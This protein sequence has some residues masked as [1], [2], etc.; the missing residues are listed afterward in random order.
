MGEKKLTVV[1][2]LPA[3]QSGGVERGTL[4]VAGALVHAGHRS[5]V[6]SAGGSLLRELVASG[7][8]HICL[9]VGRKSLLT[10]LQVRRLRKILEQEHVDIL[11]ARSRLP[12]WIAWLAWRGMPHDRRP[13]FVTTVHGLYS[14]NAYSRI[15]TRGERVI[16]VSDTARQYILDNYSEVNPGSVV[17]I[18]RGVSPDDFPFGYRPDPDWLRNWYE[19]YPALKGSRVLTLPGR[20][21][22]LK[23]HE[24]FIRLIGELADKGIQVYG[25]IVG[26]LDPER[27]QY[28][29]ELRQM[30]ADRKLESRIIFTGQRSDI[31]E[32]YA[33]S[34][35]VL[36][37]SDKPESFGRTI[38]EAL[39]LGVPAVG[40]GHGGVGESLARYYPFG[41]VPTGDLVQ[42]IKKIL[43]ILEGHEPVSRTAIFT[44]QEM[45]D[46]TLHLY[47]ELVASN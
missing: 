45:L 22:R 1:Q 16:A 12:A 43:Q 11:H 13:R 8:E 46:K 21:T 14:V 38:V 19:T 17:T 9:P 35:A 5:I 7:S 37:L 6:I 39:S 26:H 18:F 4:E 29:D 28:I 31:R 15:M 23:G 33:C 41:C 2:I 25:L 47:D 36:S 24:E 10:L 34:D 42:L 30:I 3:L 27:S 20:L 44:R 32:I 40:Y